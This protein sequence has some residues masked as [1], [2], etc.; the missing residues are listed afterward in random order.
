MDTHAEAAWPALGLTPAGTVVELPPLAGL[1]ALTVRQPFAQD[2]VAGDKAYENRSWP[3]PRRL[4]APDGVVLIHAAASRPE[5]DELDAPLLAA[6][7]PLGAVVGYARVVGIVRPA[8]MDP[9]SLA[10]AAEL[11]LN[12]ESELAWLLASP[13]RLV[14]PRPAK[15]AQGVWTYPGP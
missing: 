15:G 14:V 12:T 3:P 4:L 7:L 8:G 2:I 6:T 13:V 11:G 1:P 10:E 5:L 9:A